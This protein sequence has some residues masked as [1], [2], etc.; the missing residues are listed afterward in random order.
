M[1]DQNEIN[2]YKKK[3]SSLSI[4]D[5]KDILQH[6]NRDKVQWKYDMVEAEIEFRATGKPAAAQPAAKETPAEPRKEEKAAAP[7]P[8]KETPPAA[9]QPAKP[10]IQLRK[11]RIS[12]EPAEKS[13]PPKAAPERPAEE[14]KP[15]QEIA[16][17]P[18]PAAAQK[19]PQP[20]PAVEPKP[21]VT[22]E[23]PVSQ[24]AAAAAKGAGAS[25]YLFLAASIVVLL[26]SVYIVTIP[27]VALPGAAA[28]KEIIGKIP[29][30]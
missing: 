12:A 17:E 11:S 29:M 24:P 27:F 5:L 14:K 20:A 25:E 3:I 28:M 19:E 30:F 6:I 7:E 22:A 4:A 15:V 23:R 18:K 21:A 1:P 16:P 2:E 13:A 8:K 26:L 9:P 10:A